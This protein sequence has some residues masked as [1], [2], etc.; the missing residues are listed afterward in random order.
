MSDVTD[1]HAWLYHPETCGY[2][3]CP[4]GAVETWLAR[5][6]ERSEAP[7][8]VDVTTAH[9]PR[10]EPVPA[11]PAA[12]KSTKSVTPANAENEEKIDG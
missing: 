4:L 5:G 6:W 12:K 10:P 7:P 3:Q 2:W 1:T 9:Q 11:A 8:E